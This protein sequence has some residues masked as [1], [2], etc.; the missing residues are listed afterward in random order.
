MMERCR[1]GFGVCSLSLAKSSENS[2]LV[3][4]GKQLWGC[5]GVDA[6]IQLGG[7][8]QSSGREIILVIMSIPSVY[9]YPFLVPFGII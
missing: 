3:V 6:D 9:K 2:P 1:L 7:L 4:D 8:L 5:I